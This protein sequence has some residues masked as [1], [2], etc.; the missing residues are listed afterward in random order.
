M[1]TN[2]REY[3]SAMRNKKIFAFC[4]NMDEPWEH[5]FKENVAY[6]PQ[7]SILFHIWNQKK[8]K[9]K[10]KLNDLRNRD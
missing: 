2:I 7:I 9:K 1:K 8:K 3:Y 6:H 5:I 10:N 4:E